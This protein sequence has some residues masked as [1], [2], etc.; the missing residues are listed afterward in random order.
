M[1]TNFPHMI[2]ITQKFDNTVVDNIPEKVA[3]QIFSWGFENVIQSGQTVAVA[4][5]SRGIANY[6]TIVNAV[7]L[8]LK[9]MGLSPFIVPAMGSHGAASGAG[10]K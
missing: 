4:C 2:R 9:K 8:G 7:I 3:S 10:Q 1:A 6:D 5:S